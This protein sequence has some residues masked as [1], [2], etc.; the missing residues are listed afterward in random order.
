AADLAPSSRRGYRVQGDAQSAWQ[1]FAAGGLLISEPLAYRRGLGAGDRLTLPT[2]R[3]AQD[4]VIAGVFYDY[5][6]EHG[7][8]LIDR[9][10]YDRYWNDPAVGTAALFAAP[11][12]DLAALRQALERRAGRR[13]PLLIRASREL[14]EQ[15][16]VIFER[17]FT[18]TR[19]L[20][21][22]AVG[23]AFIGMLSALLALQLERGRD[24]AVLRAVGMTPA[25]LGRLVCLQTGLLGLIA[26]LLSVPVGLLLA[27]VLIHVI[28]RRAFGW[29]LP[30]QVAPEI[31]AQAVLLAVLAALLAG[32]YPGWRLARAQPAAALREE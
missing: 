10:A 7:R 21:W 28:Q 15:S 20:R 9:A 8:I 29:T 24:Y 32:L 17:T 13:Q 27:W 4:F 2:D 1:R 11:G 22:L 3:G 6:S 18:I 30:F 25:E 16:L 19:V 12:A 26:G 5:G 14:R 23:V 31:L